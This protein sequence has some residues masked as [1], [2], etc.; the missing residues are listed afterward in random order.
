MP[1]NT[2]ALFVQ[3]DE[4]RQVLDATRRNLSPSGELLF[5]LNLPVDQDWTHG[6]WQRA[7]IAITVGEQHLRITERGKYDAATRLHHWTQQVVIDDN[8]VFEIARTLRHWRPETLTQLFLEAGWVY[9]STPVDQ[10]GQPINAKSRLFIGRAR[11]V[12]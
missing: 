9:D 10:A 8:E 1:Y 2:L 4:L 11:V 3:A 6:R 5:D 12:G 7:P